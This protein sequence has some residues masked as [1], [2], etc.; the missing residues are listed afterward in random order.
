[1]NFL[2]ARN[3]LK[4]HLPGF[5]DILSVYGVIMIIIYG[6]TLYWY[7]WKLPSWLYFMPVSDILVVYAYDLAVNF[8]ETLIMLALPL[9]LSLIL[10]VAWYRDRF[11]SRSAVIVIVLLLGLMKYVGILTTLYDLPPGLLRPIGLGLVGT[12]LLAFLVG[13]VAFLR[14]IMDEVANRATIFVYIFGPLTAISF[15]VILVRNVVAL[16]VRT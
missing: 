13:R 8:I 15:L 1:M 5:Q 7:L 6:W 12:T 14:K 11:V 3:W 16:L 4:N 10:P 9:T 2:A